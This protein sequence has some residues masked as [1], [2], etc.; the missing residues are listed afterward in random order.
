MELTIVLDLSERQRIDSKFHNSVKMV[1]GKELGKRSP[2]GS[3]V[4]CLDA[5]GSQ[6][7]P[8]CLREGSLQ[9]TIL[10]PFGVKKQKD[11]Q[12]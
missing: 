7:W 3:S 4:Q 5:T 6:S 10:E 1:P 11:K 8:R 2:D 12:G 9:V